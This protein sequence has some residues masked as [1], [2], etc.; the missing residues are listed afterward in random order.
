MLLKLSDL[1]MERHCDTLS[2]CQSQKC[3]FF[4]AKYDQALCLGSNLDDDEDD[5][6]DSDD[7]HNDDPDHQEA[8]GPGGR[9]V[10]LLGRGLSLL[11]SL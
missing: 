8:R 9:G 11:L 7:D 6:D 10:H 3:F 4:K 5:E 2:S 1:N